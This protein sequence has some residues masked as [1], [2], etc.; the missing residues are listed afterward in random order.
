MKSRQRD[1][2]WMGS[3]AGA[4]VLLTVGVFAYRGARPAASMRL[5]RVTARLAFLLFWPSYVGG[6]LVTLFGPRFQPLKVRARRFGLAF[7]CVLAVHLGLVGRLCWIGSAPSTATFAIFGV[8]VAWT[9]ILTLLS[10]ESLG[11]AAGAKVWWIVRNIGLNYLAFLFILDFLRLEPRQTL[12][13]LAEYL[14]FAALALLGPVLR[15]LAFLR[16]D[17]P[18]SGPSERPTEV[19][20][21]HHGG[22]PPP[23][24]ESRRRRRW[25][26]RPP[27][28]EAAI[29]RAR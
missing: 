15:L 12:P 5:S 28:R 21:A 16:R 19:V 11:Q 8:G 2:A 23:R 29:D 17:W 14:P 27:G 7:A 13:H 25:R 20:P 9:S 18:R 26:W 3:A 10:I 1:A 24:R 22:G 6:A 4:A